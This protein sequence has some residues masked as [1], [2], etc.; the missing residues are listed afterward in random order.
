MPRLN[1]SPAE[2]AHILRLR[3]KNAEVRGFN[4]GLDTAKIIIAGIID[5]IKEKEPEEG[6]ALAW[7]REVDE[8]LTANKKPEIIA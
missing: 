3:A 2:H 4:E 6:V 7:L 5:Q 8:L 1:L